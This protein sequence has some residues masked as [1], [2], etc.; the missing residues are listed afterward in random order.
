MKTKFNGI[1]TFFLALLVQVTFAQER[2][3]SGVVSDETG[4]LPGVN[5]IKKGTTVGVES[6]FN[7]NYSI[8]AKNGDVLIF[9][10]VGMKTTE[11]TVGSSNQLN[12]LMESGNVLD[13]VV[14]TALGIKREKKSLGFAQ[15]T[16]EAEQLTQTRE[17]DLN[18]SIAGRVAGVQ[19][20]GAPS[21]GFGNALVRL[22]GEQDLLY[23]VDGVKV[24]SSADINTDDIENLS[25]LKGSAATALYGPIGKN[26]VVV[27]TSKKAKN[28]KSSIVLDQS[29]QVS[30]VYIL[31]DYQNEYGGG[32]SQ[33]FSTL[34]GQNIPNYAADA[35]WGPKLDGRLV[36]HWDSWI[37]NSDEF[38]ELRPWSP[39]ADNVKN[40]FNT[41]VTRNTNIAFSKGGD[42]YNVKA[43]LRN[44]DIEGVMPNSER[45]L[46]QVSVQA[47]FDVSERL[48]VYTNI[49]YQNRTTV[50]NPVG[51]YNG[52]GSGFNQ[53]WQRQ[54]DM[55]RIRKND[56]Q[57]GQWY[58]WNLRSTADPRPLYWDS[59]F[60]EVENNNKNQ[61]KD[62]TFGNFG[63]NYE[64][65]D[66]LRLNVELRRTVNTFKSDARVGFGG[67]NQTQFTEQENT[68][69]SFEFFAAA[70]YQKDL[71]KDLDLTATLGTELR[72]DKERRTTATTVGGLTIPGIFTIASS[73]DR[74]TY[75]A[76][77]SQT[78]NNGLFATASLGYKDM[79]YLD[80]SLRSDWNSNAYSKKNRVITYGLSGSFL[81]SKLI[82]S[83]AFSFGKL[84]VGYAQAPDFPRFG[85]TT[86]TY[87]LGSN[88]N[89]V[90]PF[91]NNTNQ[92][93][94]FIEGGVRTEFE[95]G[96]ELQFF[97]NRFGVDF[98]YFNRKD[99]NLAIDVPLSPAS[100][101]FGA[102]VNS[103][104]FTSKGLEIA[105][106]ATPVRNENF[107][108]NIGVNFAT[109]EKTTDELYVDPDTDEAIENEILDTTWRG[110][111]IESRVGEEYGAI[112]GRKITRDEDGNQ[113]LNNQ[114]EIQ[115]EQNQ[116]L[117]NLLPDFTGGLSNRIKYKNFT[118][119]ANV[120]FQS[121]G[122]FFS[123]SQ[124][125]GNYSGLLSSTVGNNAAGNPVRNEISGINV[126]APTDADPTATNDNVIFGDSANANTGGV[127]VSG[128]D[129]TTGQPVSYY[130][131]PQTYYGSLF[132]LHEKWLYDASYVKLRQVS[133]GYDLPSTV[134]EN[135]F[136]ESISLN[137]FANNL[138]LIYSSV[139][140]VDPSELENTS[141]GGLRW[142]EGGQLPSSRSFGINVKVKF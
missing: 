112:Y 22:R 53:W 99:K 74:P 101:Y 34:N 106:N 92:A 80:G 37:P 104:K 96:T 24:S 117:G 111:N 89:G 41:G 93:N 82:E 67:L 6:D 90:V 84:R 76:F 110:I 35:S 87:Q 15:Q 127:L 103:G 8:V 141:A 12:L 79:L 78:K 32:Y 121:G 57:N 72:S 133:L 124:M 36:R 58:S 40:F 49:N 21:T 1:L 139:E 42:G 126:P 10:F 31:P 81:F 105:L 19:I 26:G 7:G 118:L 29:V 140:G 39:N 114:G 113:V 116:Y 128:V 75:T 77:N 107:E 135:S 91:Y 33:E 71:T 109:L 9:S 38:G 88:N 61:I 123:V 142:E 28:G 85:S 44:V 45:Q 17:V 62:A 138:W 98:T 14:V 27:I 69:T 83:E 125:F 94:P 23:V 95:V 13:E 66:N 64:V 86:Q 4:P 50:N 11:K 131:E 20:L 59:P 52:L 119:S 120:D 55:D 129:S 100:G 73:K 48:N 63:L 30:N 60:F 115:F 68:L 130:V 56:F 97:R 136:I 16:V 122:K 3:I 25:V 54:L 65:N 134:F 70:T 51:G 132:A 5:V 43:S 46:N 137:A 18:N 2:T 102:S 47:D 108:W